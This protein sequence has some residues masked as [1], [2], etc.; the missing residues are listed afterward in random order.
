MFQT[1][2]PGELR[3][4]DLAV[5]TCDECP[6]ETALWRVASLDMPSLRVTS[7]GSDATEPSVIELAT[8]V[9]AA[10]CVDSFS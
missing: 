2:A 6:P 4:D 10:R 7:A 8:I 5:L 9:R 3:S 1:T